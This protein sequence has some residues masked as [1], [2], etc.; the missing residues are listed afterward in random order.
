VDRHALAQA[1]RLVVGFG[2]TTIA[3]GLVAL[4]LGLLGDP[5]WLTFGTL[6]ALSGVGVGASFRMVL[7]ARA[8]HSVR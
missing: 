1:G 8:G 7:D 4:V 2:V 5:A 6:G 3:F